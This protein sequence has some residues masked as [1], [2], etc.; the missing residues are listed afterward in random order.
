[1]TAF[2]YNFNGLAEGAAV[3]SAAPSSTDTSGNKPFPQVAS[4]A[5]FTAAAAAAWEGARGGNMVHSSGAT[6]STW[7]GMATTAATR[8]AG[9][10]FVR[11]PTLPSST[12]EVIFGYGPTVFYL[13]STG[14]VYASIGTTGT[15]TVVR[16]LATVTAGQWL[17]IQAA[18]TVAATNGQH[19]VE[20]NVY[21]GDHGT[22]TSGAV[23]LANSYDSGATLSLGSGTAQFSYPFEAGRAG[24][25]L[26]AVEGITTYLTGTTVHYDNMAHDTAKASGYP[27]YQPPLTVTYTTSGTDTITV[28]SGGTVTGD[29]VASGTDTIIVNAGGSVPGLDL[30]TSG[31]DTIL[32]ST[33]SGQVQS[34]ARPPYLNP[35]FHITVW[36]KTFAFQQFVG[37]PVYATVTPRWPGVG[38][39]EV[40][41]RATD[42]ANEWL[43]KEGANITVQYKDSEV[44]F[45]GP[46][47]SWQG[48][49]LLGGT[50]T[51][52]FDDWYTLLRETLGFVV[53]SGDLQAASLT[54]EAQTY[55][56]PGTTHTAGAADGNGYY[57]WPSTVAESAVKAVLTANFTRL[58]RPVTVL[59]DQGRGGTLASDDM[60][61]VRFDDLETVC[62]K[63]TTLG[64]LRIRVWLE[65]GNTRLSLE[66]YPQKTYA[67][68]LTY[69]SGVLQDGNFSTQAPG[70]TRVIVGGP[71][72]DTARAFYG[73]T[74]TAA[75]T[76]WGRPIETFQDS[77]SN[78][79]LIWPDTYTD[80]QK[81][82]KYYPVNPDISSANKTAFLK[83]LAV[84]AAD[85][86]AAASAK[87]GI[88]V[89]LS[90]TDAWHYGGLDG[91]TVGD[92]VT[93][94]SGGVAFTDAITE[95][96]LAWSVESF[97]VTPVVG[98]R[99]DDPDVLLLQA[100]RLLGRRL[101]TTAIER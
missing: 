70:A 19:R 25:L 100:V 101:R 11:M 54:D 63:I 53:P 51:Y 50:V 75:E 44:I 46:V 7:F 20:W 41:L 60:P 98:P 52:Q 55:L 14:E 1:M 82:P 72:E 85:A 48:S 69:E 84:S 49:F 35:F 90:E 58:N 22:G 4:G 76:A 15:T 94:S 43:Q 86:L 12:A 17:F 62:E 26:N 47:T 95:A 59:P 56:A 78:A 39:A 66:T 36:D 29:S 9:S 81:V 18:V 5:T 83:T 23:S 64:A 97:T 33:A 28:T 73:S 91:F 87:S 30:V 61:T 80:A 42:P 96:T 77:T 24:P 99:T 67:H 16:N 65:P 3:P 79:D 27:G 8:A 57:H 71:G 2:S 74:D 45:S 21:T 38:T 10:L 13:R 92:I 31:T 88:E 37:D 32:V 93:V 40:R 34:T 68:A 89:T 6:Y